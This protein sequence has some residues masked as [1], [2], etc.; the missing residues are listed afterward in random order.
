VLTSGEVQA[1]QE[2]LDRIAAE[3]DSLAAQAGIGDRIASAFMSVFTGADPTSTV[4]SAYASVSAAY[5]AALDLRNSAFESPD[6][7]HEAALRI[8]DMANSLRGQS[9]VIAAAADKATAS[10]ATVKKAEEAVNWLGKKAQ[11]VYDAAKASSKWIIIGLVA[12]AVIL[13]FPYVV[14]GGR[15]IAG[16]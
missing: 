9:E 11:D 14:K 4:A 8:V 1:T 6:E 16:K 12:V 10:G 2:A 13:V 3:R 7:E 5:D 15:A